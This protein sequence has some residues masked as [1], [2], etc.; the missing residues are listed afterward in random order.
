MSQSAIELAKKNAA[1][2]G[3]T[4]ASFRAENVDRLLPVILE[5]LSG[6]EDTVS[7]VL[8]PGRSGVHYKTILALRQCDRVKFS[9]VSMSA[10]FKMVPCFLV[11]HLQITFTAISNILLSTFSS[12]SAISNLY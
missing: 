9:T 11:P 5:E 2:N 1:E 10:F 7:V 3:V 8:N 4:N 12:F 6:S